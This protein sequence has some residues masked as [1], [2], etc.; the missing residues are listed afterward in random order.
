MFSIYDFE[1]E[2]ISSQNNIMT[3]AQVEMMNCAEE[4]NKKNNQ[5]VDFEPDIVQLLCDKNGR[6]AIERAIDAG[7]L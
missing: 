6:K 7:Y 2:P 5:V 1:S 3:Y 4:E